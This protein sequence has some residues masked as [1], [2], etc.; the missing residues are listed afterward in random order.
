MWGLCRA[1]LSPDKTRNQTRYAFASRW[2]L[3]ADPRRRP[4]L[5]EFVFAEY[6][7]IAHLQADAL[8]TVDL[9]LAAMHRR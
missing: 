6:P 5:P 1:R 9:E 3:T 7:A 4:R 2:G 8:L